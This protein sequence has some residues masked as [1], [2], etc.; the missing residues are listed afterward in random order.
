MRPIETDFGNRLLSLIAASMPL[1]GCCFYRVEDGQYVID[2]QLF[3]L[4]SYWLNSYYHHFWR[5][6]PLHPSKVCNRSVP[7]LSLTRGSAG[8]SADARDYFEQF[9]LPQGTTHQTELYFRR[10]NR[11]IAGASL[12]RN[13]A[14]GAFTR[15]NFAFLERLVEFAD[16]SVGCQDVEA[17]PHD[18]WSLT[19]RE[20][21]IANLMAAAIC[22][23]EICRR[24][25]IQLPTVKTHVSR[26]LAKAGVRSRAE[27]IR[28]MHDQRPN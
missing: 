23:K 2:H 27:F 16:G 13:D 25:D 15:E 26:I 12:L 11:I 19:P 8:E 24:L 5:L 28:K 14:I 6:D 4:S 9:L 18:R 22:N 10:G 1:A 20:R 7:L 21:D 17:S 3:R